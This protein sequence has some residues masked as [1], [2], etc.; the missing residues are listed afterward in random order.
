MSL[1]ICQITSEGWRQRELTVLTVCFRTWPC[2]SY[3]KSKV[4]SN[5]LESSIYQVRNIIT[6][7]ITEVFTG[8]I[9][10][11]AI[12]ENISLVLKIKKLDEI[13]LMF[14]MKL[15]SLGRNDFDLIDRVRIFL[16][17]SR[18]SGMFYRPGIHK[19]LGVC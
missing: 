10:N 12:F 14:L 19:P 13:L 1:F 5:V 4:L 8:P 18:F 3:V 6:V 16:T 9:I 2:N 15:T 7:P 11:P 17:L